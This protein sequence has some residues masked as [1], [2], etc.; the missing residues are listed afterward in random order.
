MD[1]LEKKRQELVGKDEEKKLEEE[2][3][4]INSEI[5]RMMNERGI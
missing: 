2:L 3:D 5:E 4:D 1:M